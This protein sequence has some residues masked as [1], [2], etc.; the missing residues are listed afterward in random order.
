MKKKD[1]LS[2]VFCETFTDTETSVVLRFK[3]SAN[4]GP[5]R[6]NIHIL[7]QVSEVMSTQALLMQS[8]VQ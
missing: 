3:P 2:R 5:K 6:I 8:Q 1:M 4:K 7:E